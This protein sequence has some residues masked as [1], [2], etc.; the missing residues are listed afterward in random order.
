MSSATCSR[1]SCPP[2]RSYQL[3]GLQPVLT[4]SELSSVTTSPAPLY[5]FTS[6]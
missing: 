4:S 2:A 3:S 1:A 5:P 6:V